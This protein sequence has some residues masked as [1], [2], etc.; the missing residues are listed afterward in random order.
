MKNL[1]KIDKKSFFTEDK[2]EDNFSAFRRD[3]I[4]GLEDRLMNQNLNMINETL[5]HTSFG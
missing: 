3:F 2:F 1:F 4:D 5:L